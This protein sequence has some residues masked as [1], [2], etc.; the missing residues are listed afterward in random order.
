MDARTLYRLS[1]LLDFYRATLQQLLTFD[2]EL[3][4]EISSLRS[5]SRQRFFIDLKTTTE[6][7]LEN[8]PLCPLDLSP[9]FAIME[10]AKVLVCSTI[11]VII[12]II[13]SLLFSLLFFKLP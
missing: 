4:R 13:F 3:V 7:L 8:P 6:R 10:V 1:N 2:C 5:D 11:I 9:P 12:V